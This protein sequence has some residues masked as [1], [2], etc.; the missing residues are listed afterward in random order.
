M[1]KTSERAEELVHEVAV[2]GRRAATYASDAVRSASEQ[3][4]AAAGERR[5]SSTKPSRPETRTAA[6]A[7]IRRP[8]LLR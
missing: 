4:D 1:S 6:K 3:A 7:A 8:D 5:T 2:Q